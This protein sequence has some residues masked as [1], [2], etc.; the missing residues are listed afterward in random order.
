MKQGMDLTLSRSAW[1][2]WRGRPG[3]CLVWWLRLSERARGLTCNYLG[4]AIGVDIDKNCV[5]WGLGRGQGKLETF[6]EVSVLMFRASWRGFRSRAWDCD[7]PGCGPQQA[8]LVS[9]AECVTS[10][11]VTAVRMHTHCFSAGSWEEQSED[12]QVGER[13]GEEAGRDVVWEA[14]KDDLGESQIKLN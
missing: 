11:S 13:V 7:C 3:R 4:M 10:G 9:R 6:S 12:L 5:E 8:Q 2:G 14:G 1:R